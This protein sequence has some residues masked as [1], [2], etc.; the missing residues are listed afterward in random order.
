MFFW[1]GV[2]PAFLVI[3]IMRRVKE[4]PIWLERRQHLRDEPT[5]ASSSFS[6]LFKGRLLP[7]TIQSVL[8]MGSLLSMY[9]SMA[10]LY[11]KLLQTMG[12]ETLALV[13]LFNVGG[14]VGGIACGRLSETGLGRRGSSALITVLGI[15][16][17]PL[18]VFAAGTALLLLGSFLMGFSSGNFGVIPTYLSE[19]FPTEVRAAGAGF[20]YQAGGGVAAATPTIIGWLEDGGMVLASA[21]ALCIAVSGVLVLLLLSLGPE[22]RGRELTS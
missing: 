6:Q 4:S 12:R 18:Y 3:W 20:A 2:L 9:Y 8:L 14:I 19:R 10:Y 11:P 21:M 16:A 22:T 7:V 13:V 5:R 1:I 15:V 17:I